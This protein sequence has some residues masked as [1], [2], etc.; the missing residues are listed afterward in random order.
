MFGYTVSIINSSQYLSNTF[1]WLIFVD[2]YKYTNKKKK[3][4][5]LTNQRPSCM[6]YFHL[7]NGILRN[8]QLLHLHNI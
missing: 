7:R 5:Y 4:I 1:H 6:I 8:L 2:Y 3:D